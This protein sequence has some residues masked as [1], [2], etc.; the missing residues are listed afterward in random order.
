MAVVPAGLVDARRARRQAVSDQTDPRFLWWNGRRTPWAEATVHVT[1]LG[2]STV[3][4][5]F[6]GIRA[7]WNERESELYIFRL[8][9]HLRRLLASQKLVRMVRLNCEALTDMQ[10]GLQGADIVTSY[11]RSRVRQQ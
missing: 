11:L 5:V 8:E 3:A 10:R 1:E 7:Y 2:W 6:E 4:A 9:D